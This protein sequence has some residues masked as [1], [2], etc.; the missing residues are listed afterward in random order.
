MALRNVAAV[1]SAAGFL[2]LAASAGAAEGTATSPEPAPPSAR[3]LPFTKENV[4]EVVR[5][6]GEQLQ[7]CYEDAMA[8]RG[9]TSKDAPAGRVV[10]SWTITMQGLPSEVK[11]KRTQIKDTLVTDCM[12]EAI[13]FWEFPKPPSPQPVEFPFDLKPV[14]GKKPAATQKK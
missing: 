14:G 8:R 4:L 6:H 5:S 11:V 3:D 10:M 12:V 1:L 9:A 7:A 2:A 13:R